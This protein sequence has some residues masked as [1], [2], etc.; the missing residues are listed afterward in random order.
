MFSTSRETKFWIYISL[1]SLLVWTLYWTYPSSLERIYDVLISG[2]VFG[3]GSFGVGGLMYTWMEVSGAIG[4]LV[5][6]IGVVLGL[7]ALYLLSAKNKSLMDV[8]KLLAG[9][10]FIEAF[11]YFMVG[12]PSGIFMTSVGYRGQYVTLGVAYFLQFLFTTPFLVILG[13]KIYGYK[14]DAGDFIKWVGFAFVGYIG[15]LWSNSVF[16]WFDMISTDGL[17]VFFTGIRAVGALNAFL[18]MSLAVVFGVLGFYYLLKGKKVAS[19]WAGLALGMVGL[20]YLIYLVY[21]YFGG[22]INFVMIVEVWAIPL[23]GLGVSIVRKK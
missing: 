22:M 13:L 9:A 11:Y 17:S 20:H 15:A 19:R 5:R 8:K 3:G 23:L 14:Q 12:F 2:Q 10:L 1:F 7:V 21:S 6:S 18:V 4:T 16:R